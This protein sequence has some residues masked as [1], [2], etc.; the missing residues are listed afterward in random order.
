VIIVPQILSYFG[1]Y[2]GIYTAD[3]WGK[4]GM[5]YLGPPLYLSTVNAGLILGAV[6]FMILV[7][8]RYFRETLRAAFSGKTPQTE[9]SY[10]L[11]YI[12]FIIGSVGL[13]TLFVVSNVEIRDA[14]IGWGLVLFQVIAMIRVRAYTANIE[15]LRGAPYLKLWPGFE[16]MPGAPETPAGKLFIATHTFRWVQELMYMDH[17][18]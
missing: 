3:M 5:I 16:Y 14:I 11:A 9:M 17:I 2:S 13:V 4:W 18:M 15:F 6:V 8:W 10:R 7:N 1:Y 12:L